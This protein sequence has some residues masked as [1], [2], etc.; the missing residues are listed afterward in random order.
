MIKSIF[1]GETLGFKINGNSTFRFTNITFKDFKDDIFT[2]NTTNSNIY[3]TNCEFKNIS[4]KYAIYL[5]GENSTLFIDGCYFNNV[6]KYSFWNKADNSYIIIDS[7]IFNRADYTYALSKIHREKD[8]DKHVEKIYHN[9]NEYYIFKHN[10][11]SN[12]VSEGFDCTPEIYLSNESV[13]LGDS[14]DIIADFNY[15]T[16][17]SGIYK[18][19][20]S[21]IDG[22]IVYINTDD[23]LKETNLK[24][25][26]CMLK[27]HP[28]KIRSA[29]NHCKIW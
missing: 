6:N 24:K 20:S 28:Y 4:A 8:Y 5:T 16:N 18:F 26:R 3:F 27:I 10:F 11:I 13:K 15:F 2:F 21:F 17:S 22:F 19:N 9:F 14:V 12:D 29:D 7:T 25:F 1:K 23:G